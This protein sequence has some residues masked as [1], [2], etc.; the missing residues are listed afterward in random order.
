MTKTIYLSGKMTGLPE[1]G[2]PLF[3]KNRDF[4]IGKEWN[5]ISPA[6][7]DREEGFDP[8]TDGAEFTE[9]QYLEVIKRDYAALLRSDAIAFMN[10]WT[11]SRGAKLES[12][13]ANVLK[14]DRYRVDADN[15]YLEKELVIGFMG[16]ATVGKD[17]IA[18][19]FV[20]R[21]G[22]ERVGFADS[23]KSILY[24]LNP[25]IELFNND[26]VGFWHVQTLVDQKGWDEAKKE[27]EV[28]QL[29][30]RLGTEG[31]RVALGEDVWVKAL[32]ASPHAARIVI[33]DVRF[34]N[35]ARA[36]R[37]RG[38]VVVRV[39]R[40]GVG[41]INNHVSDRINFEADIDVYNDSTPE[42]AYLTILANL[43]GFGIDL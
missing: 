35:E 20:E 19:E 1:F 32:F 6:D 33:P 9:E 43:P 30:Q 16:Y 29:L 40:D 2:F 15:N 5:V 14:L 7:I 42:N 28:R 13:F 24:A 10:N 31:G 27:P 8:T 22:F 3:D 18:R 39:H 25:R 34:E 21:D 36:I 41:P 23:L 4:L 17:R 26:F 37:E 12:D 11:D 38:G